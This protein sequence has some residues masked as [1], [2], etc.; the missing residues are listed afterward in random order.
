MS[1]CISSER[2]SDMVLGPGYTTDQRMGTGGSEEG[3]SGSNRKRRADQ[4]HRAQ[5][6]AAASFITAQGPAPQ[7]PRPRA[8]PPPS[9]DH[10]PRLSAPAQPSR[11]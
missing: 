8:P 1:R 5:R 3:D 7:R 6:L 10:R 4:N 9:P 2:V 11:C